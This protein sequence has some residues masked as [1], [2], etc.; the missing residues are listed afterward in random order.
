MS[1]FGTLSDVFRKRPTPGALVVALLMGVGVACGPDTISTPESLVRRG[2]FPADTA[3][4]LSLIMQAC[5]DSCAT[6]N[7]NCSVSVNQDDMEINVDAELVVDSREDNCIP[8]CGTQAIVDCDVDA[9][10]A[11]E[12]TVKA[13]TFLQTITIQ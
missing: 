7:K 11:G 13:G 9:L 6:Y 5:S 10:S 1:I 2:P 8:I 3:F 12:Y 4:R